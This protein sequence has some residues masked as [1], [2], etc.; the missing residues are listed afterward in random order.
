MMKKMDSMG[1]ISHKD[2]KEDHKD[3]RWARLIRCLFGK[4]PVQSAGKNLG[5]V[6]QPGI[7][8]TGNF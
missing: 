3:A 5:L 6:L 2:V 1:R 4:V 8:P 7:M